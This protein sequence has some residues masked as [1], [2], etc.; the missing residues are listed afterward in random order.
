MG[1]LLAGE[2]G[3]SH[4]QAGEQGE[5]HKRHLL[6]EYGLGGD[7]AEGGQPGG[8][9]VACGPQSLDWDADLSH[10][11]GVNNG[12]HRLDATPDE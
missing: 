4:Q 10:R 9:Q 11:P 6:G 3:P 2:G 12:A 8:P 1:R 5:G 7:G